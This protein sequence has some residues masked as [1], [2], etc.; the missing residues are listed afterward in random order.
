MPD[1]SHFPEGY[2]QSAQYAGDLSGD[3]ISCH[4]K[5]VDNRIS[6]GKQRQKKFLI[7]SVLHKSS[8]KI[9]LWRR[10]Q[11]PGLINGKPF[12]KPAV[13]L[14]RNAAGFR[15]VARP[16]EPAG[17]QPHIQQHKTGFIMIKCFQPV[18]PS[19][20]EQI[21]RICIWIHLIYIPDYRHEAIDGEAHICAPCNKAQF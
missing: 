16:L 19:A 1:F 18:A 13:F 14:P 11:R 3:N 7:F 4:Q 21:Q 20:A 5:C 2:E 15:T 6:N 12:H 17:V 8:L 9:P 10:V